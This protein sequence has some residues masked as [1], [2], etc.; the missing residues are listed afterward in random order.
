MTSGPVL[1][2]PHLGSELIHTHLLWTT[3]EEGLRGNS[4]WRCQASE[5][6]NVPLS[7]CPSDLVSFL[8][9]VKEAPCQKSN[10]RDKGGYFS[11]QFQALNHHCGEVKEGTSN[12][13]S[14]PIQS[15]TERNRCTHADLLAGAQLVNVSA[16]IKFSIPWLDNSVAHGGLGWVFPY[17]WRQCPT[18]VPIGQVNRQSPLSLRLS[19]QVPRRWSVM[20]SWQLELAITVPL[21]TAAHGPCTSSCPW[22]V[23]SW[24]LRCPLSSLVRAPSLISSDPGSQ[25]KSPHLGMDRK[26]SNPTGFDFNGGFPIHKCR[27]LNHNYAKTDKSLTRNHL[28][29]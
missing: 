11:L 1:Y 15:R 8:F 9:A 26:C 25:E 3:W 10:L 20:T 29:V 17:W 27:H 7:Q 28:R 2:F 12:R 14:H 13:W 18:A 4:Q 5:A 16:F 21:L 24:R 22:E 19:S 23:V 6:P